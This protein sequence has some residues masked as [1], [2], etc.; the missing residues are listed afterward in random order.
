MPD[1]QNHA[2]TRVAPGNINT[3]RHAVTGQLVEGQAVVADFTGENAIRWPDVLATL[4]VAQQD[5]IIADIK[6]RLIN[7]AAGLDTGGV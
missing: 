7:M 6:I 1:L 2:V 4:S 3:P 5:A